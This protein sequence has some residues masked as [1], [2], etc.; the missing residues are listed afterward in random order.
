MGSILAGCRNALAGIDVLRK[1]CNHPD[2][3][4][5]ATA[6]AAEDYG[7]GTGG[8]G[9]HDACM[10]AQGA[11]RVTATTGSVSRGA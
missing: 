10:I 4:E 5:R 9:G 6:G 3:L 2:L 1:I 8:R 11:S 7:E